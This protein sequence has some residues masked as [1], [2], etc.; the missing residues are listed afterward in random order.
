MSRTWNRLYLCPQIFISLSYEK[1]NS[2]HPLQCNR[3]C[4]VQKYIPL[5][6]WHWAWSCA[7]ATGTWR[8]IAGICCGQ[9]EA[10]TVIMWVCQ[11]PILFPLPQT[12]MSW[13]RQLLQAGMKRTLEADKHMIH[14]LTC[15]ECEK[16]F[17]F[18][19]CKPLRLYSYS[20]LE[21]SWI[22]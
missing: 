19:C 2:F 17:I 9:A 15:Q 4:L 21:Q 16:L 6:H 3:Q 7:L 18:C 8:D 1:I 5:S 12:H 22:I 11:L 14:L 13:R 10:L 20:S